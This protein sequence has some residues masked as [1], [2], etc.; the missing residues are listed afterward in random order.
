MNSHI[1]DFLIL[2]VEPNHSI[3]LSFYLLVL[4]T[5]R[6]IFGYG[7]IKYTISCFCEQFELLPLNAVYFRKNSII[8]KKQSKSW[9]FHENGPGNKYNSFNA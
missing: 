7:N 6:I 1:Q 3:V 2:M 8:S 9:V 4:N 5:F